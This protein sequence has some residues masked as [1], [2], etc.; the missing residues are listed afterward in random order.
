MASNS[1]NHGLVFFMWLNRLIGNNHITFNEDFPK[2]LELDL[3]SSSQ[4]LVGRDVNDQPFLGV[5]SEMM[6]HF[7]QIDWVEASICRKTGHFYLEA[8][9]PSTQEL[10]M[11]FGIK[12]RRDR[13]NIFC[14]EGVEDISELS[15]SIKVFEQDPEDVTSVLF[16]DNHELINI[17]LKEIDSVVEM[18]TFSDIE[19]AK[20][21]AKDSGLDSTFTQIKVGV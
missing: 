18:G 16:A 3:Y 4:F 7:T 15:L 14:L 12:M 13:L 19:D 11:A 21:I 9:N 10:N 8:K 17:T 2:V 6:P 20:S 1:Q 5:P